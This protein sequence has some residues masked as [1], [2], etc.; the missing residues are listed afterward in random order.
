M[1][2]GADFSTTMSRLKLPLV[3]GMGS[4][5]AKAAQVEMR[6]RRELAMCGRLNTNV[7]VMNAMLL[8]FLQPRT[9]V[10][11][12]RGVGSQDESVTE[13]KG[14][15]APGLRGHTN[16]IKAAVG[17]TS[18]LA[19]LLRD[20]AT[21]GSWGPTCGLSNPSFVGSLSAQLMKS[22]L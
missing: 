14:R 6:Q 18:S 22:T 16:R 5:P 21:G 7:L 8:E 3:K 2:A 15:T 9:S 1:G 4:N 13:Q 12:L 19:A 10:M 20:A 11:R 17:L